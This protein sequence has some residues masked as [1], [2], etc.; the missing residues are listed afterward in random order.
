MVFWLR[1]PFSRDVP[2]SVEAIMKRYESTPI[3]AA[4]QLPQ[5]TQQGHDAKNGQRRQCYQ[6]FGIHLTTTK[7]TASRAFLHALRSS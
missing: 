3:I 1:A 4:C 6:R 2:I 7:A 5:E